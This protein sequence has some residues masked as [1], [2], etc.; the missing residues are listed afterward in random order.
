M[1]VSKKLAVSAS[2][3]LFLSGCGS[4]W[5]DEGASSAATTSSSTTQTSTV[6]PAPA[7]APVANTTTIA[8]PTYAAAGEPVT[9]VGDKVDEMAGDLGKLQ[10]Q[11]AGLQGRLGSIQVDAEKRS[12]DYHALLGMITARLQRGSTPGNPIWLI[13]GIKHKLS[14]NKLQ[15]QFHK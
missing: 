12:D 4:L 10:D 14:L 2:L 9:F 15:K 3:A 11:V 13:N 5:S 8:A 6:A 7:P 1:G